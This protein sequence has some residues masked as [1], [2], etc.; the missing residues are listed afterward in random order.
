MTSGEPAC[1]ST[2]TGVMCGRLRT[3]VPELPLVGPAYGTASFTQDGIGNTD[4]N[5]AAPP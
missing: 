1:V 4:G 5:P 3:A 2:R